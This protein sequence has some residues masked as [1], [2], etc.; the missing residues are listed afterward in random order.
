MLQ[1]KLDIFLAKYPQIFP[2]HYRLYCARELGQFDKEISNE[3]CLEPESYFYISV[4]NKSLEICTSK[5]ASLVKNELGENN[6]I[7]LHNGEDLI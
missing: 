2:E 5:I 1:N 4:S 3:F 6:V 7:V